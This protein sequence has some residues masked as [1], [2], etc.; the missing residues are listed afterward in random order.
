MARR[1]VLLFAALLLAVCLSACTGQSGH[2]ESTDMPVATTAPETTIA[3]E[4]TTVPV[5]TIVPETTTVPV[6]T[7]APLS[8]VMTSWMTDR[9]RPIF[10]G[11]ASQ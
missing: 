8:L 2:V 11:V 6:A 10:L 4:T 3:P 1:S 7:T 9:L 5:A